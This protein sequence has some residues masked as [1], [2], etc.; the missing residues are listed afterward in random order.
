MKCSRSSRYGKIASP[1]DL[2]LS[3]ILK[4]EQNFDRNKKKHSIE[5]RMAGT[6]PLWK[7]RVGLGMINYVDLERELGSLCGVY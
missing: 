1:V 4:D 3:W 7:D 2:Y 6:L 5:E